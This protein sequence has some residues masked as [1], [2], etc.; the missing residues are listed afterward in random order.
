MSLTCSLPMIAPLGAR[1][2]GR[3]SGGLA[4]GTAHILTLHLLLIL[5]T[6]YLRYGLVI[7]TLVRMP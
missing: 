1:P 7:R 4:D 3:D 2:L 6:L 5:L